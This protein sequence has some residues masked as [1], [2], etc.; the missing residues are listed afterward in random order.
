MENKE[1]YAVISSSPMALVY[2]QMAEACINADV[3]AEM[4]DKIHTCMMGE[5]APAP[6]MTSAQESNAEDIAAINNLLLSVPAH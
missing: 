1:L 3:T 2:P 5:P 6:V 4:F